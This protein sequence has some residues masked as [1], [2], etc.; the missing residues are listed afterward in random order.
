M[1]LTRAERYKNE[2]L[3][4]FIREKAMTGISIESAYDSFCGKF[5]KS[6][7]EFLEFDYW[8]YR[9]YDGGDHDLQCEMNYEKE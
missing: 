5:G 7:I 9:F 6:A 8:Y 1:V 2:K 4:M 3:R